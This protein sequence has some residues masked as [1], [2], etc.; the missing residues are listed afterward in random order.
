M[1]FDGA[2]NALG[3]VA[4]VHIRR[5]FLVVTFPFVGDAVNVGGTGLIIKDMEVD[6]EAACFHAFHDGVVRGDLV[7]IGL[8]FEGLNHDSV[9]ANVTASEI[10]P[11]FAFLGA[12][13]LFLSQN[14]ELFCAK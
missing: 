4:L 5:Y 14:R 8:G 10:C 7:C 1:R 6:G 12:I 2:D 13:Q 11:F 3:N 9:G